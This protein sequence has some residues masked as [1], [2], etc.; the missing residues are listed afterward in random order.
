M[1][2]HPWYLDHTCRECMYR[3]DTLY[4]DASQDS[5]CVIKREGVDMEERAC[6]RLEQMPRFRPTHCPDDVHKILGGKR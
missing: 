4:D 6:P 1:P 3:R 5:W 2:D